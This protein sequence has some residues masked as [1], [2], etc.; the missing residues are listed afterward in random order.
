MRRILVLLA[1]SLFGPLCSAEVVR[2][3]DAAGHVSYTDGKCPASTKVTRLTLPE[4]MVVNRG[5]SDAVPPDRPATPAPA[6]LPPPHA[7]V[8]APPA[9]VIGDYGGD[10]VVAD[11]GYPY[12]GYRPVPPRNM[13][14]RLRN[15]DAAGCSDKQGNHYDRT[16]TLNRYKSLDGRT[17]TPVGTTVVCR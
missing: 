11:Y 6:P 12:G 7:V 17:C 3:T 5:E 8:P 16:G 13:G 1:L 15:C 2:C 14:P 9:P 10:P 4:P